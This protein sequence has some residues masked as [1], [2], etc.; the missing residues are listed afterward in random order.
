MLLSAN[1]QDGRI[2][3]PCLWERIEE[4]LMRAKYRF[5]VQIWHVRALKFHLP[6][7]IK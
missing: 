4:P 6:K 5:G 7:T 1:N 2:A 3:N